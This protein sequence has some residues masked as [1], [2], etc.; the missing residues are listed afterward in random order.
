MHEKTG[1]TAFWVLL[2]GCILLAAAIWLFFD[3]KIHEANRELQEYR[4]K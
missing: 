4:T 2:I 3:G 1:K